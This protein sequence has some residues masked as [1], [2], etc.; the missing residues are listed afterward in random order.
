MNI[1]EPSGRLTR[2]MLRSAEFDFQIKYK[3]VSDNAHGD[4][5]CSLLIGVTTKPDDPDDIP[6]YLMAMEIE[7]NSD[8]EYSYTEEEFLEDE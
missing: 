4:S 8:T 7:G 6:N 5:L 3:K 2:W 1:P